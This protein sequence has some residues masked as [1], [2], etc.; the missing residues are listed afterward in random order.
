MIE[1]LIRATLDDVWIDPDCEGELDDAEFI[2]LVHEDI[3]HLLSDARWSVRRDGRYW[4]PEY[5]VDYTPQ[6]CAAY[7]PNS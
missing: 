3:D 7:R 5:K 1:I 4:G 6:G 2:E